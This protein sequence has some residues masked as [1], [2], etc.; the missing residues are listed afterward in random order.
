MSV[1][2]EDFKRMLKEKGFKLT[3]QRRTVLDVLQNNEGDHLTAE[4]IYEIVR[5]KCPEIGL[6]TVYRTIQLLH[7]LKLIDK[8]NLDDGFIRYEIGKFNDDNHHHHHHHLICESCGKVIEVEDDL[9]ES[10]EEGFEAKYDFKVTDHKVKF[11]GICK[12]CK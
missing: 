3:T 12:N 9:M 5:K 1:S 2:S 8:L 6:A 4:E 11:Y 10:I 7:E